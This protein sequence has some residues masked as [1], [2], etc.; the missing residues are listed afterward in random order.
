MAKQE[1]Q[2]RH[3]IPHTTTTQQ[4]IPPRVLKKQNNTKMTSTPYIPTWHSEQELRNLP[5]ITIQHI[6]EVEYTPIAKLPQL[7]YVT[8]YL[9]KTKE[10]R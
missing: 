6:Q 1:V 5:Q 9:R 10:Q 4:S 2:R 8:E 3:V 7:E